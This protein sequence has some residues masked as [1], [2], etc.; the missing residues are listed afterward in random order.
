MSGRQHSALNSGLLLLVLPT[1]LPEKGRLRELG[2][3]RRKPGD[4][5]SLGSCFFWECVRNTAA[6][7]QKQGSANEVS[8]DLQLEKSLETR[9]S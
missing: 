8:K 9:A 6:W 1:L 5:E 2:C 7:G 4:W 3:R